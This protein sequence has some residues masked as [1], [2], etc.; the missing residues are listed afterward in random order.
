MFQGS[1]DSKEFC[2]PNYA[3]K[4]SLLSSS[5]LLLK[6]TYPHHDE[7]CHVALISL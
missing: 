3:L 5:A 6:A 7:S 1:Y 2:F 4:F